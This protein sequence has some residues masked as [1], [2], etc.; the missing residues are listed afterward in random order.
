MKSELA[1]TTLYVAAA[2]ALVIAA[3]WV[4]PESYRP[5]IFSDQ[6]EAFFPQFRD[7]LAVKAIEV[8]DY[9]EA[10]AVARPLKIEFRKGRYVLASH[11]GYPAE[12]RDR[13]AKT[14]AA[15]LDLKRDVVVSDRFEEH[16][17]YGVIDPLDPKNPSLTGRGKRVTLRN[18]QGEV[19]ADL[20]FGQP[21]KERAGFRYARLPG[22]KR[23]Y[24]VKTDADP[25]ARFEDWVEADLLKI[26]TADVRRL[27]LNIYSI[28]EA[29]G[30]LSN[31]RRIVVSRGEKD[32]WKTEPAAGLSR[33]EIQGM[34]AALDQL[35]VVAARPKPPTLAAQLK[36]R[37]LQMTLDAV[38]SLRQRG[39]FLTPDGRLLANEGELIVETNLGLLYNLRFGEIVTGA[40]EAVAA[41]PAARASSSENRYLFVTVSARQGADAAEDLART[42]DARF[43]D[44]YYVISGTDF[45]RLRVKK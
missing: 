5:E 29:A 41:K 14:A 45:A 31:M 34:L 23:T 27:T 24:A 1:R 32:D 17:K 3:A 20:V 25:S 10:E 7:V 38:M 21:V 39:F 18:A 30:R 19:L 26:A 12:A 33:A 28:D 42:L 13:L 4:E 36:A 35:R 2:L 43:A 16:G 11:D 6:G 22:R 15:L 8:M 40:A 37:Q 9:N 44:W